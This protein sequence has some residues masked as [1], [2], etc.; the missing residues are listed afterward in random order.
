MDGRTD[1]VKKVYPPTNTV[2]GGYKYILFCIV[3]VFC[4]I[5]CVT[6][7]LV[8][9]I[10]KK[11]KIPTDRPISEK[12]GQE[13]GNKNIFKVGLRSCGNVNCSRPQQTAT[14][15]RRELGTSR[16]KVLSLTTVPVTPL[17]WVFLLFT[18]I[19]NF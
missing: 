10:L 13:R 12:Q 1:N 7:K 9:E 5:A 11:K 16:P 18:E 8:Y 14:R 3:G 6:N 15:L 2:C 4:L 17:F 19:I